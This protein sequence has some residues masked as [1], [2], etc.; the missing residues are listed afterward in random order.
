MTDQRATAVLKRQSS[1]GCDLRS[2]QDPEENLIIDFLIKQLHSTEKSALI[3]G[4]AATSWRLVTPSGSGAVIHAVTSGWRA[5]RR[6]C[7]GRDTTE[8]RMNMSRFG[9]KY[10][11]S[12]TVT[13]CSRYVFMTWV[14]NQEV[15]DSGLPDQWPQIECFN[16]CI[17]V[18]PLDNFLTCL[19]RQK[20]YYWREIYY[21][22][23]CFVAANHKN[24]Q[25]LFITLVSGL[26]GLSPVTPPPSSSISRQESQVINM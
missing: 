18:K 19:W 14:L 26:P 7:G 4:A 24:I 9:W 3:N 25:Q 17:R 22:Y 1:P 8:G 2:Q 21:K 5:A 20:G 15:Q 6:P 12:F 10:L 13:S 11:F 16:I 23:S